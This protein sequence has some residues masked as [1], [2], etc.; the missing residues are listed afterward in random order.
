MSKWKLGILIALF[1]VAVV[2]QVLFS[3][4][5]APP[6]DST[7]ITS[8]GP[9]Q[10]RTRDERGFLEISDGNTWYRLVESNSLPVIRAMPPKSMR[11]ENVLLVHADGTATL[12]WFTPEE[13]D[14]L[15]ISEPPTP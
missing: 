10:F 15:V 1:V 9:R 6:K 4:Y 8:I 12:R 13:L 5:V 3:L 2:S 7:P 14:G 11:A